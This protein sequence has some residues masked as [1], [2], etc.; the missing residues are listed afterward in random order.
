MR[1][2]CLLSCA[3]GA[4]A[5]GSVF[6]SSAEA[7]T[8]RSPAAA[9]QTW[10]NTAPGWSNNA[11]LGFYRNQNVG[12]ANQFRLYGGRTLY[13][14]P[15]YAV[16]TRRTVP[17]AFVS[18]ATHNRNVVVNNAGQTAKPFTNLQRPPN[19]VERYWPLLVEA[20]EDPRTGLVYWQLP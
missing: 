14:A 17:R 15:Y 5:V 7:Q 4:I 6:V 19:A 11:R 3:C 9:I 2:V 12:P 10:R 16:T 20:R 1:S 8:I 13:S 18:T